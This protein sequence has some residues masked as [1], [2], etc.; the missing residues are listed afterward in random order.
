MK[1]L[2]YSK[3]IW[4]WLYSLIFALVIVDSN[5]AN[6]TTFFVATTGNDAG[7]GSEISPFRTIRKGVTVLTPGDILY[8]KSGTYPESILS[9]KTPIPNGESWGKPI[10][11]SVYPGHAVTITPPNGHAFFWINDGQA[12]YLIINGF[13]VDGQNHALHGFKFHENTRYV[14]IQNTEVKNSTISGILVSP[15]SGISNETHHEFI[16]MKV[17]HNGESRLDHGFYVG[18][19]SNLFEG[20]EVFSH[21]GYGFHIYHSKESTANHNMVRYNRVHNNSLDGWSCGILLSSGEGNVAHSNIAYENFIGLCSQYRSANAQ[22]FN[23]IAYQ[24]SAYGIYVGHPSNQ[25]SGVYNNTL[26]KNGIHGVFVGD[27]SR[28][29][30]VKNNIV[31]L[32]KTQNIFE[33]EPGL[34]EATFSNN[35]TAD[36]LFVNSLANDFHLQSGSPAIDSGVSVN[37]ITL[38]YD[39]NPRI[40]GKAPDLGAFEMPVDSE[41]P[42]VPKGFRVA[43]EK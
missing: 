38:D 34:S 7:S 40:I 23:N 36:P 18:T 22:I 9:W 21:P 39:R 19:S 25:D 29:A 16:N 20:N 42:A 24:N 35:F 26:Y 37:G 8:V 14:R 27:G 13:I 3:I 17:H 28:K 31:H 5:L 15:V 4:C 32:N 33:Q 12:K 43:T 41:A 10:T 6:A 2:S 30:I 1:R 11:V